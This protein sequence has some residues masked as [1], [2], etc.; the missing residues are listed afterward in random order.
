MSQLYSAGNA[1]PAN[2][3]SDSMRWVPS[4][5]WPKLKITATAAVPTSP[6]ISDPIT[7]EWRR[8]CVGMTRK[9]PLQVKRAIAA[10]MNRPSPALS[11]MS[12]RVR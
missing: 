5:T 4:A 7:H 2:G 3:A 1:K 8:F 10:I 11:Q 12:H 9:P 6:V